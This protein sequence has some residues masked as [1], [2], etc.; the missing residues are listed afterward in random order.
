MEETHS[1]VAI[2][3]SDS[4][5]K[6]WQAKR[7]RTE[8]WMYVIQRTFK[9]RIPEDELVDALPDMPAEMLMTVFDYAKTY[10]ETKVLRP[11][12]RDVC[13]WCSYRSNTKIYSVTRVCCC[14]LR[15]CYFSFQS[16]F[17]LTCCCCFPICCF[18]RWI[19]TYWKKENK[20]VQSEEGCYVCGHVCSFPDCQKCECEKAYEDECNEFRYNGGIC[21]DPC[22]PWTSAYT[23]P[24][25]RGA[26]NM[27]EME[28]VPIRQVMF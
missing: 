2:D 10:Q 16:Y 14:C 4:D 22:R 19:V 23:T 21:C 12:L 9:E 28:K 1:L 26:K 24:L 7:K 17:F 13:D 6:I 27:F 18:K 15:S 11:V 5:L 20:W 25:K 3:L 8:R